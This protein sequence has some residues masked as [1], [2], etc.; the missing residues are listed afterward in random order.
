MPPV[1]ARGHRTLP[2]SLVLIDQWLVSTGGGQ[3]EDSPELLQDWTPEASVDVTIQLRLDWAKAHQHLQLHPSAHLVAVVSWRSSASFRGG[4]AASKRIIADVT[5]ISAAVPGEHLGEEV[6][7]T[8][9][10]V[11]LEPGL[12]PPTKWAPIAPASIVWRERRR[13]IIEGSSS[14]LP[15]EVHDFAAAGLDLGP[16]AIWRLRIEH[17]DLEAPVSSALRLWLN[18]SNSAATAL[19]DRDAPGRELIQRLVM[20]QVA[21]QLVLFAIGHESLQL[22][23]EYPEGSLGATLVPLVT[24]LGRPLAALRELAAS[25]AAELETRI[26]SHAW[27]I[28]EL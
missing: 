24:A 4:V 8:L 2:Q 15:V 3:P 28:A 6:R 17:D 5:Q 1:V 7:V 16:D 10:I 19:L 11:V 27:R 13:L 25:D 18:S 23:H 26:Q 21:R 9:D 14:R 12:T 20:T 22:S